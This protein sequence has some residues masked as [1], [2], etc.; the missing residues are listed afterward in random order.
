M[1]AWARSGSSGSHC[2]RFAGLLPLIRAAA[3]IAALA[4]SA[5][6]TVRAQPQKPA[7]SDEG[8]TAVVRVKTK[9][10]P[11]ARTAASLGAERAGSGVLVR[12]GYVLTIGY[13]VI[14]A[15][16]IEVSNASG[17]TVPATLAAYDH[18]S[19]FGL[20]KLTAPL[21]AKPI[22]LGDAAGLGER[23]PALV[24][25]SGEDDGVN[26]V[27]VVS[28]R[29]FA[30]SWEYLLESAIFTYPPIDNW[31]G[32]ALVGKRGELLGIGSLI[33]P[34]AAE[35]NTRSPGNMFVPIDLLKPILDDLIAEGRARRPARP[36]VG[37]YTDEIRGRIFVGRVSSEGP[38]ER[39]G[40][41]PGDLVLAVGGDPVVSQAD[42]YRKLWAR[43]TAGAVIP[44]K[45]LQ[46][47]EVK[48]VT[49]RSID[50]VE[51]FR[52]KRVY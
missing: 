36:W 22:P 24:I 3:L 10:L 28:R 48:E 13:L 11:D 16:T 20:V 2:D 39:A 46:G 27:Y 9:A 5:A 15:D 23:D 44:L 40:V 17:Q 7:A 18:A 1:G 25:S 31:S 4:L 19:G 35:P 21:E 45:V 8:I 52:K 41:K 34:D 38:A 50:R 51:W 42:F 12:E 49:V 26:V 33:V 32:A 37:L 30:G 6:E 43:G 47:I 14:E 29:P